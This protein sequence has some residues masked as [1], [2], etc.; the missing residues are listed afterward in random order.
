MIT[1][2]DDYYEFWANAFAL[3]DR[4]IRSTDP[5]FVTKGSYLERQGEQYVFYYSNLITGK[6]ILAAHEQTMRSLK[7][8][9][10]IEELRRFSSQTIRQCIPLRELNLEFRDVDYSLPIGQ[11]LKTPALRSDCK[12]VALNESCRDHLEEFLRACSED[13]KDTLDLR[14]GE[15]PSCG[16]YDLDGSLQGVCRFSQMPAVPSLVDITVLVRPVARGRGFAKLLVAELLSQ[17]LRQSLT[18]KYRVKEDNF[19]SRAIAQRLGLVQANFL[20]AWR[21]R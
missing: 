14:L 3:E 4:E 15:D 9:I 19:A 17:A 16:L 13:E 11:K 8:Q 21:C 2:P 5:A 6:N 10:T 12:I 18:P 20:L 7:A 1:L